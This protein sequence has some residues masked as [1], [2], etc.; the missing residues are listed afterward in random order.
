MERFI[1]YLFKK[2]NYWCKNVDIKKMWFNCNLYEE[3]CNC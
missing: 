1:I 2:C 3:D